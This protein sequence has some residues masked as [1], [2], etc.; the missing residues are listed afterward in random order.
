[1]ISKEKGPMVLR[2]NHQQEGEEPVEERTLERGEKM[3]PVSRI[4]HKEGACSNNITM[5]IMISLQRGQSEENVHLSVKRSKSA[6]G[7]EGPE[8]V[9]RTV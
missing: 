8:V 3:R 1:V 6:A 2:G 5:G 9:G 7:E 4:H